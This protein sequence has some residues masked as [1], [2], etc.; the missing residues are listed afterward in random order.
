MPRPN[1]ETA[2]EYQARVKRSCEE[3]LA[4]QERRLQESAAR[5]LKQEQ[6]RERGT[7]CSP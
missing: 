4:A 3:Q 6:E 5:K 2:E 1:P 7:Y